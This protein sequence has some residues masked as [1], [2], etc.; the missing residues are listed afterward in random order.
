MNMVQLYQGQETNRASMAEL[1][2]YVLSK[3]QATI[4]IVSLFTSHL[5]VHPNSP[6]HGIG[7]YNPNA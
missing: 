7:D 4:N 5:S 2:Y 1:T 6:N 3:Q